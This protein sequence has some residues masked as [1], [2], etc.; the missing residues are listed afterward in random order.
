MFHVLEATDL[1]AEQKV[2]ENDPFLLSGRIIIATV[3]GEMQ[4][5]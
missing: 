5:I 2:A 3:M 4:S 1:F